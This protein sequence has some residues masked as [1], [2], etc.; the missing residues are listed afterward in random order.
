MKIAPLACTAILLA[1]VTARAASFYSEADL[2]ATVFI[3]PGADNAD[4]GPSFGGRMGLG[5]FSWLSIG[6]FAAAST[7]E[8]EV[9]GPMVGQ[10]FQLY[11][12]GGELRI[13]VRAGKVGIFAEGGGGWA[14]VSTNILDGV[15]I[16]K[17]DQ[18]NGPYLTAGG[19][20]EYLTDNPRYAIGLAGD[21]TTFPDFGVLEAVSVR[22]YL[23]YTK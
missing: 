8:A 13:R 20:L 6:G 9:P 12:A 3:G 4:P 18:H 15:S 23:R 14:F 7:H 11:Q 17:P 19:G 1:P 22:L 5:I 2:G 16:T 21:F 10:F